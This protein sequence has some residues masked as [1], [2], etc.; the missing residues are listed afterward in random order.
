M[1]QH[2]SIESLPDDIICYIMRLIEP[3]KRLSQIARFLQTCKHNHFICMPIIYSSELFQLSV[4]M[5]RLGTHTD[6]PCLSLKFPQVF[7]HLRQ[8]S[9]RCSRYWWD[10]VINSRTIA[11][12]S[13]SL[14]M[15]NHLNSLEL[16]VLADMIG[17]Y[18]C[19]KT[20]PSITKLTLHVHP[21][22]INLDKFVLHVAAI[23][24]SSFRLKTFYLIVERSIY[25]PDLPR[26]LPS[27]E[28][29]DP[30][31]TYAMRCKVQYGT[32][33]PY[34]YQKPF[35]ETKV[36][37]FKLSTDTIKV[38]LGRLALAIIQ[39]SHTSI[40]G[41]LITNFDAAHVFMLPLATFVHI[42]H[43]LLE[44]FE[45]SYDPCIHLPKIKL[46]ILD[47]HSFLVYNRWCVMFNN[48][49]RDGAFCTSPLLGLIDYR[50]DLF[51]LITITSGLSSESRWN[52]YRGLQNTCNLFYKTFVA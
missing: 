38:C 45:Y 14:S 21:K 11:K 27:F 22:K 5:G 15:F 42:P 4:T 2:A 9:I 1:I 37:P 6:A 23:H 35:K 47:L 26:F 10:Q 13:D 46:F 51:L 17:E 34:G 33:S 29:Y 40:V 43:T 39:N 7:I 52:Y 20:P 44:K 31:F 8:L 41:L 48:L 18:I 32:L 28:V 49:N 19:E 36:W 50:S 3:P 16:Y 24:R 30:S 12:I 25:S